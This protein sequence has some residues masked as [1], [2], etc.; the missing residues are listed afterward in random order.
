MKVTLKD[1]ADDM[2]I[3]MSTVS[4]ALNAKVGVSPAMCRK[5]EKRSREMGYYPNAHARGLITKRT[6]VIGIIYDIATATLFSNPF[7]STILCGIERKCA[8]YGYAMMFGSMSI[9][10][11][12]QKEFNLPKFMMEQRVD[13]VILLRFVNRSIVAKIEKIHCPFVLIDCQVQGKQVDAV[14]TDNRDGAFIATEYLIGLGHRHI[15]FV[16]GRFDNQSFKERMEGYQSALAA[17]DLPF[18]KYQIQEGAL[19]GSGYKALQRLLNLAPDTTGIVSCNDATAFSIMRAIGAMNL[20]IPEDISL[21][22][23]DDIPASA[24]V[25]PSLTTMRVDCE[26]MGF[27]GA[28]KL[29]QQLDSEASGHRS[30]TMFPV[31][32]IERAST[33]APAVV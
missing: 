27:A 21:I 28:E 1:I 24:E 11:V 7:W 18:R 29:L 22:G 17:H 12:G 2:G 30:V 14:V 25:H 10:S 4:R 6:Q 13:G 5:I 20:R 3:N 16:G 15:G 9:A 33:A 23:F 26:A 31:E 8:E 19:D 32:L